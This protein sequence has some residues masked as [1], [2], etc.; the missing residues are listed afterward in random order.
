MTI[1]SEIL[2]DSTSNVATDL[3]HDCN[4]QE[5]REDCI[6]FCTSLTIADTSFVR[7]CGSTEKKITE[8]AI[9]W[10]ELHTVLMSLETALLADLLSPAMSVIICLV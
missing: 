2:F 3:E 6:R 4:N 7:L 5:K 1:I 10:Q 8:I 9:H